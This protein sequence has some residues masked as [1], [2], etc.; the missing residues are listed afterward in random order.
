MLSCEPEVYKE[1]GKSLLMGQVSIEN[2]IKCA[3]KGAGGCVQDNVS[4][5]YHS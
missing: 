3:R 5:G 2:K 4:M 1:R